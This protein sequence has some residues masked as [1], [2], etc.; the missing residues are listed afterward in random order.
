MNPGW[1]L[2]AAAVGI[3]ASLILARRAAGLW[4]GAMA[5]NNR[6]K[7]GVLSSISRSITA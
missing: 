5:V 1:L 2:L 3:V 4:L 7:N 6:R